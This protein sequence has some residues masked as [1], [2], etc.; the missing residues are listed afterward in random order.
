[1]NKRYDELNKKIEKWFKEGSEDKLILQTLYAQCNLEHHQLLR[2]VKDIRSKTKFNN[3]SDK[4]LVAKFSKQPFNS[5]SQEDLNHLMQEVHNRYIGENGWDVTRSVLAKS[6]NPQD[7]GTFGYC[8]Y[9][10]DLLFINK[11]M[12]D[13]AKR[14]KDHSQ[15][16]NAETVGKYFLDT[17]WHETKHIIQYED[18]IDLALGKKQDEEKAF[19]A[20][21]MMVMMTNFSISDAKHDPGYISKWR[22]MYRFH[23]C[24]HEANYA[25]LKKSEENTEENL[26]NNYDYQMYASD[27]A[28]LA[29][30]FYPSTTDEAKNK[31][32]IGS[33]VNRI[34]SYLKSQIDYFKNGTKN[35]P[36][37][38]SVLSVIDE[39]MKEDENG[40][41]KFRDRMTKEVT[42]I[43]DTYVENKKKME[44]A[45]NKKD[46]KKSRSSIKEV[47]MNDDFLN[48]MR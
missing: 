10:D 34:E 47:D 3:V 28:A 48:L 22:S 13:E 45:T 46:G 36:L 21:A 19:S 23:F 37:K 42:E 24:E 8:C 20:A 31:A 27:S 1:M 5:Y 30:G 9:A 41:S 38:Q 15:P 44:V 33:R 2:N 35:C 12:I 32:S 40:H 11:D 4:E 26:K 16:I 7:A 25:A 14:I 39:Y 43:V 29:L 17:V 6:N 18:G